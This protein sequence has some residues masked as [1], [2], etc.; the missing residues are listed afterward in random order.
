MPKLNSQIQPAIEVMTAARKVTLKIDRRMSFTQ[1]Q[2][3][4]DCT[5]QS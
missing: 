1:T 4:A 2:N 3:W 5:Y